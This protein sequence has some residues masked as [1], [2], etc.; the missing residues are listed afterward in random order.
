MR[1]MT[2]V[3]CTLALVA[4]G[5]KGEKPA[6]TPAAAPAAEPAP[7]MTGAS[8][9]V[10]MEFDGKVA[11]FVPENVTIK[12]GDVI[13]FVVKSGPPHNVG[14]YADSIPAGAADVL[15]KNMTETM[16]PLTG[17]MKVGM[18]ES[19]EVSFAGAPAGAYRYFCTPH[20]PF[21]MHGTITVQ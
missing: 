3:V 10:D 7:A 2:A 20:I 4:C 6:E 9:E 13:K 8:H 16:A 14:F 18:G 5:G 19:Y 1:A 12:S 11:K 15:N 17:P 21:G